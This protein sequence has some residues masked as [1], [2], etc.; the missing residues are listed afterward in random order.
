MDLIIPA[1]VL[2]G[3]ASS[4]MRSPKALLP[5]GRQTFLARVIGTLTSGGV[6]EIVVVTGIHHEAIAAEVAR[7]AAGRDVRVV[8]NGTPGADQ[9]SSLLCGLDAVDGGDIVAV[10]V[11]LVDHPFVSAATVG[12]LLRAFTDTG[13]P[14]VRPASR[15][16]HGH[17]VLF[18]RETFAPLR[19]VH[20][21]VGAKAV[22]HAF[23]DRVLDVEVD[24]E[25]VWTDIDT[26]DA[27]R[28]A[29]A[30]FTT[31]EP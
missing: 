5:A 9:R 15:G 28:S 22:V 18:A 10:L 2:S 24:D 4:R 19:A 25:G 12:A 23:A 14:I 16:R 8:Q 21:N 27:Y 13:A 20:P 29:L 17:P 7:C 1:L 30:R 11:A 31:T 26:P 6:T 3:G